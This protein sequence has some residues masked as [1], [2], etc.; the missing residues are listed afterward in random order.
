MRN[1][2]E[3]ERDKRLS[4]KVRI[5]KSENKKLVG[6]LK[7]S[8]RILSDKLKESKQETERL[9]QLFTQI[10]PLVQQQLKN[11][12]AFGHFAS[13]SKSKPKNADAHKRLM[14]SL[15]VAVSNRSDATVAS[16]SEHKIRA[17]VEQLRSELAHAHR[18]EEE[19]RRVV[20]DFERRDDEMRRELRKL[21]QKMRELEGFR[22]TA[23][24]YIMG[25]TATNEEVLFLMR[26]HEKIRAMNSNLPDESSESISIPAIL[27]K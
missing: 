22:C 25:K 18:R 12:P 15:A 24:D 19:L 1:S 23:T 7:D 20:R 17:R 13:L 9:A 10:W 8:E 3:A 16:E 5:L 4:D 26:A 11:D 2:N 27:A 6:L 14:E 21:V